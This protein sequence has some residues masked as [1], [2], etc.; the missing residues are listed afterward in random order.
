MEV[1]FSLSLVFLPQL[2]QPEEGTVHH[3]LLCSR[4][5]QCPEMGAGIEPLAAYNKYT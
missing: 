1:G 3:A 4:A 2:V 5:R